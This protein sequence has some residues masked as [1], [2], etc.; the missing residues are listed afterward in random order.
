MKT[1]LMMQEYNKQYSLLD[2]DWKCGPL[3][4]FEVLKQKS[5]SRSQC[6]IIAVTAVTSCLLAVASCLHQLF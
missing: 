6:H 3:E 4:H 2:M 1:R 5:N